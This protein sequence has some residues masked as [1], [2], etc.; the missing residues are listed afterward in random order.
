V[1]TRHTPRE[2]YW[3]GHWAAIDG[4]A[5]ATENDDVRVERLHEITEEDAAREGAERALSA[6]QV[7]ER[8]AGWPRLA[9]HRVGFST[10][11]ES[12]NGPGSWASNPWVWRIEFRRVDQ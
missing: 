2:S 10:L 12:I 9:S 5:I 7:I 4:S 11:W 6:E 8:A 3:R 1:T